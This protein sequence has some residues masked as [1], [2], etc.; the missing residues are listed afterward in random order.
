M[1]DWQEAA[2]SLRKEFHGSYVLLTSGS[3]LI[4][5]KSF[6]RW[7]TAGGDL[8]PGSDADVI[9]P[10]SGNDPSVNPVFRRCLTAPLRK[11][12]TCDAGMFQ[13]S[14]VSRMYFQS[15]MVGIDA[16]LSHVFP[17][18]RSDGLIGGGFVGRSDRQGYLS[19][20][21]IR[22][23]DACLKHVARAMGL[24]VQLDRLS[25]LSSGLVGMLE[26]LGQ[27][28]AILGNDR[29]ILWTNAAADA[30]LR[31]GTFVVA[32]AKRLAVVDREK[33]HR[34]QAAIA[35]ADGVPFRIA[36]TGTNVRCTV[37]V[38]P[39][40]GIG[41]ALRLRNS[42]VCVILADPASEPARPPTSR[43]AQQLGLT[44]AEANVAS[45]LPL[46]MSK[47]EIAERLGLSENTVRSHIKSIG[48]KTGARTM[49]A[50]GIL[51]SR[52][53]GSELGPDPGLGREMNGRR[54]PM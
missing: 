31:K 32:S 11:S 30:M 44:P 41:P 43:V 28:V 19:S 45:L 36:G 9:Q 1:S 12:F 21:D 39:A 3:P 29:K 47:R 13:E 52:I 23:L 37:T 5:P 40:I 16:Q 27:A 6:V 42:S 46:A 38:H 48:D 26:M 2:D 50:L 24:W 4:G 25:N 17:L 53:P 10:T 14:D 33:E 51:V 20:N 34:F 7:E 49:T 18:H 22:A 54:L 15:Y 35:S 8:N